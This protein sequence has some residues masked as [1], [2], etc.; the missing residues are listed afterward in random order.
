[1]SD[2]KKE[3]SLSFDGDGNSVWTIEADHTLLDIF[4]FLLKETGDKDEFRFL[5]QMV[6]ND[7]D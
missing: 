2:I 4:R 6:Y 1:M 3:L 5:A 7:S